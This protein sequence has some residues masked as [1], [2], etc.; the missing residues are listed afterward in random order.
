MNY[1]SGARSLSPA[2]LFFSGAGT[3][4]S[5]RLF[6][7]ASESMALLS[8]LGVKDFLL[9]NLGVKDSVLSF[10]GVKDSLRIDGPDS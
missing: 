7:D 8:F 10:L 4:L 2:V 5:P 3:F 1:S 9:Q 6:C